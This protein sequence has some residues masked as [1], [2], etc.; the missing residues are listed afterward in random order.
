MKVNVRDSITSSV[1]PSLEWLPLGDL[2]DTHPEDRPAFL[3]IFGSIPDLS[4]LQHSVLSTSIIFSLEL[5]SH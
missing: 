3:C 1:Y 4:L 5:P 2:S